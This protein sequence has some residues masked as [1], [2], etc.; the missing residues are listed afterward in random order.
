ML[1]PR[2]WT[3]ENSWGHRLVLQREN[4][5]MVQHRQRGCWER[6]PTP[7]QI[8]RLDARS[9]GSTSIIPQWPW[10]SVECC[11]CGCRN[12]INFYSL[13]VALSLSFPQFPPPS[14]E[15]SPFLS[16]PCSSIYIFSFFIISSRT[17]K[18]TME[19]YS[20]L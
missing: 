12:G 17:V 4:S 19:Y 2:V 8:P 10:F 20:A 9:P 13:P 14:Q 3:G 16:K 7:A 6:V 5:M 1:S 11:T 15:S 18:G